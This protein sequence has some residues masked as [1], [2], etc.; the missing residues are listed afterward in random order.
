[1]AGR[2]NEPRQCEPNGL[3]IQKSGNANAI[4]QVHERLAAMGLDPKKIVIFTILPWAIAKNI[5]RTEAAA[6][7]ESILMQ[8]IGRRPTGLDQLNEGR[9]AAVLDK[10]AM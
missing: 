3:S 1:M 7:D 9:L 10:V 8:D 2:T 4:S 5:I 6:Q